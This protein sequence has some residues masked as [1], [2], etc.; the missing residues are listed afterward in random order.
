MNKNCADWDLDEWDCLYCK[1]VTTCPYG[2]A[3]TEQI[4]FCRLHKSCPDWRPLGYG[5]S[6]PSEI[7]QILLDLYG[8]DELAGTSELAAFARIHMF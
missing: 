7:H 5:E 3:F 1:L 4:D 2:H 8:Q 6:I